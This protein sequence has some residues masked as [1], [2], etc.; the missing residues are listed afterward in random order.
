MVYHCCLSLRTCHRSLRIQCRRG[1][2]L[3]LG[4]SHREFWPLYL[5]ALIC[6]S[7]LIEICLLY[8]IAQFSYIQDPSG[9]WLGWSLLSDFL[10]VFMYSIVD[11]IGFSMF[12]SLLV[13]YGSALSLPCYSGCGRNIAM[14]E[15]LLCG[16]LEDSLY[17][18]KWWDFFHFFHPFHDE[19]VNT[20]PL[21]G[22]SYFPCGECQH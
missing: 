3:V 8:T 18:L 14:I 19:I 16:I 21:R 12:N 10:W 17:G 11:L 6:G 4:I 5:K 13:Y 15:S 1:E 2:L 9:Y 22:I 7:C 20:K